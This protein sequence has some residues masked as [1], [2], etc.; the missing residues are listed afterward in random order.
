MNEK[1]IQKK[2]RNKRRSK[3]T[4]INSTNEL[5]EKR[6]QNKDD[7]NISYEEIKEKK[8][9]KHKRIIFMDQKD[10]IN[11]STSK[12]SNENKLLLKNNL[13]FTKVLDRNKYEK[14][15]NLDLNNDFLRNRVETY[16][17]YKSN[18]NKNTIEPINFNETDNN[19]DDENRKNDDIS[20]NLKKNEDY[21][22]YENKGINIDEIFNL[23]TG[24]D[25]NK[26]INDNYLRIFFL[27]SVPEDRT[28]SMNINRINKKEN[29]SQNLNFKYN[30]EILKNNQIYFFAQVKKSFPSS[31]IKIFIKSFNSQYIKVGKIISNF[32]KNNFIIYKGDKKSNYE[33]LLNITYDYNFFGN[34]IRK[35]TINKF[36]NNKL[37]YTL[38]NDLPVWDYLYKTYKL[39]FNG[40]VKQTSKKNFILKYQ[41]SKENENENVKLLQCG[42]IDDDCYALDFIAPLSPFEAFTI[43]I[44]SIIDKISCD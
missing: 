35:M 9:I 36:E 13:N 10:D 33:K 41:N 43:S 32:L 3:I 29:N 6:E 31:N 4:G 15:S 12:R 25:F 44:T 28:L 23:I 19:I 30:L 24:Y 37:Q 26:L 17:F 42:K 38:C 39:N 27:S 8:N 34:K 21:E 16:T 18:N 2:N 14:I 40:R 7:E 22:N 20:F 11:S 5:L 1:G